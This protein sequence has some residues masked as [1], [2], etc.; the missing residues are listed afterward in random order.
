MPDKANKKDRI[1]SI[2]KKAVNRY[3]REIVQGST[4]PAKKIL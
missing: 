2:S 4:E 3:S 1:P